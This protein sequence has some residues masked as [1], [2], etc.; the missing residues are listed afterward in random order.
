MRGRRRPTDRSIR[1]CSSAS[2][3]RRRQCLQR[4]ALP[5]PGVRQ[6]RKRGAESMFGKLTWAA[7]PFDEPIA[8]VAGGGAVLGGLAVLALVTMMGWWPYLWKEW[9][10][11]VDHKRV[12]VMYL[13]LGLIMLLRGFSDAIMMRSQ[14]AIAVGDAQG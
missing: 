14:Q 12:G 1:R 11:S 5:V 10:T 8:L 7:I 2:W 9:L 6:G 3:N 4:R 13:C